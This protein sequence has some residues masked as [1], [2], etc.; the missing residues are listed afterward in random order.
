MIQRRGAATA[1]VER[2]G[3]VGTHPGLSN[4]LLPHFCRAAVPSGAGDLQP[5]DQL[6][7]RVVPQQKFIRLSP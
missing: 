4:A 1:G 7:D 5:T 6:V 2:A 3:V